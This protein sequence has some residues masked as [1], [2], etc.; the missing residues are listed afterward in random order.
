MN[1]EMINGFMEECTGCHA[2]LNAC[3]FSAITM[4]YSDDGFLYPIVNKDQCVDCCACY[5]VC[6]IRINKLHR[7]PLAC[8]SGYSIDDEVVHKSSS[9]GVFYHLA[10]KVMADGGIVFGAAFD[11]HT[12]EVKSTSSDCVELEQLMRSKYVQSR[13][14]TTFREV[15]S[16]LKDDRK[17]LFVGTPCQIRGLKNYLEYKRVRGKLLTVDFMCHGV[18]SVLFFKK[19][20]DSLES[21][22]HSIITEV[23]FREKDLGWRKQVIKAYFENGEI[24]KH[25]SISHFYYYFFLHNYSLRD[26]CYRCKEYNAHMSDITVA[27]DWISNAKKNECGTSLCFINTVVGQ[28]ML[29]DISQELTL[30]KINV[31]D[32]S[33]YS[34]DN[35]S[36]KNKQVWNDACNNGFSYTS[37]IL[38]R[39]IRIRESFITIIKKLYSKVMK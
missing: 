16:A 1:I 29:D 33:A 20:I 13:I 11:C 19:F 37:E 18:P 39:K 6:P 21:K 17:V 30:N 2:C 9:G 35:Y 12:N 38:F 34:H 24:W 36:Q 31:P 5:K 28:Q 25:A 26:S 7:D 15:E 14:G 3:T 8:Y 22:Y 32:V 27:D 10:H 4:K 23:T